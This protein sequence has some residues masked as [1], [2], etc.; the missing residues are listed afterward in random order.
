MKK[1]FANLSYRHKLFVTNMLIVLVM[2]VSVT[3]VTTLITQRQVLDSNRATL[4]L[5]TE[6]ALINFANEADAS[7]RNIYVLFSSTNTADQMNLMRNMTPEDSSYLLARREL[8]QAVARMVSASAP[9]DHAS[10]LLLNGDIVTGNPME[11]E[12]TSEAEKILSR[13]EYAAND[14]GKVLWVRTESGQL[15]CVRD[16]YCQMPLRRVGKAALRVR[17]ERLA[18]LGTANGQYRC[19]LYFF[20]R[21]GRL[22]MTAGEERDADIAALAGEMLKAPVQSLRAQKE[23]YAV[24]VHRRGDWY[25]V[26]LLPMSKV[27]SLQ[28]SILRSGILIA[29]VGAFFGLVLASAVSRR[30]SAQ[31]RRLVSSM[32]RVSGGDLDEEIPVES[33]DDIGIL[34]QNFNNMTRKTGELLRRVVREEQD[35]QRAEYQNLEYEYRFLQWQINPHFIYNALETV[36]ALAKLNG[37]P[38]LSDMIVKLSAFFRANAEAMSKKFITVRQEFVSVEQYVEIY[39]H[40]Y[41]NRLTAQFHVEPEAE[42]ALVPTMILQPIMENA[43]VH[44]ARSRNECLIRVDA[45]KEGGNLCIRIRDNGPGMQQETIDQML[46]PQENAPRNG[47]TSLGMRNVMERMRL[48][49]GEKASLQISSQVGEGTCVRLILPCCREPEAE[50]EKDPQIGI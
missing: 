8:T 39:R 25:A 14:F 45:E 28:R 10:V 12:A 18:D 31:I 7:G 49:Y 40:I 43:L 26:G 17:Q 44:G 11:E 38:E 42:E 20:D 23:S 1:W 46:H 30:L 24:S 6:Q 21:E 22:M 41:G 37:N 34:T 35:R 47:R 9:Y 3:G 5:L 15:W 33:Q 16:V 4:N 13:T 19:S 36:N 29:A 50:A 48:L 27:Q 2:A 32:D